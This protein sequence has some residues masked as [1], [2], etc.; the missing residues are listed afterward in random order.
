MAATFKYFAL[1]GAQN[2]GGGQIF[3]YRWLKMNA[4]IFEK[5]FTF[6]QRLIKTTDGRAPITRDKPCGIEPGSRVGTTTIQRHP[7]KCLHAGDID[8]AR[9]KA[10]FVV[11]TKDRVLHIPFPIYRN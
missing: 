11:Q 6:P 4:V 8:L 1:L 5:L 2:R 3:V 7:R 9:F 10:V